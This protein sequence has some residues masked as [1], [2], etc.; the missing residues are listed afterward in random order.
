MRLC[1]VADCGPIPWRSLL[2]ADIISGVVGVDLAN[3]LP[4][5]IPN[6]FIF[7]VGRHDAGRSFS[8]DDQYLEVIT[9]LKAGC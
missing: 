7:S 3:C 5:V 6:S 4:S 9:R 8:R 2:A 1:H